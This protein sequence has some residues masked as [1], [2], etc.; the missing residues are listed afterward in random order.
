MH[1][2]ENFPLSPTGGSIWL[3]LWVPLLLASTVV[4]SGVLSGYRGSVPPMFLLTIPF[5]ALVGAGIAF[6]GVDTRESSLE[7]IFVDLVERGEVTA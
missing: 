5:I 3:W 6:E 7:D 2:P 1:K 4:I